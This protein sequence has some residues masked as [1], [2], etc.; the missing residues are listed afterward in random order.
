MD[1]SHTQAT[2]GTAP[3]DTAEHPVGV[4][5]VDEARLRLAR[6]MG[7]RGAYVQVRPPRGGKEWDVSPEFVRLAHDDEILRVG[8]DAVMQ[9][10]TP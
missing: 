5:V 2:E 3:A 4:L 10:R 6:V 1:D 8:V 9:G 7:H